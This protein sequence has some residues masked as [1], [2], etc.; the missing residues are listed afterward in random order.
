MSRGVGG[1]ELVEPMMTIKNNK[2]KKQ[3][4]KWSQWWV[5]PTKG[6]AGDK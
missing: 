3:K 5:A 2:N 6:W 1:Q 4:L